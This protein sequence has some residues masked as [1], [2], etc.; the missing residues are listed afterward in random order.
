MYWL[1]ITAIVVIAIFGLSGF[2]GWLSRLGGLIFGI[3]LAIVIIAIT[4]FMLAKYKKEYY[5]DIDKSVIMRYI[6]RF[7]SDNIVEKIRG[8]VNIHG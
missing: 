2:S 1:D 6:D 5:I 4:P 3:I 7:V 8:R